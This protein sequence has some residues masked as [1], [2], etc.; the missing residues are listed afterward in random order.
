MSL[1]PS[2]KDVKR[3]LEAYAAEDKVIE[4][5]KAAAA[6]AGI[7]ALTVVPANGT[8]N[9]TADLDHARLDTV[10]RRI[11]AQTK[12]GYVLDRPLSGTVTARF[13][14][15]PL[16]PAIDVLLGVRGLHSEA[17][18]GVFV[19]RPGR[20]GA[21]SPPPAPPALAEAISTEVALDA[22]DVTTATNILN[23]LYPPSTTGGPPPAVQFGIQPNNNAVYLIGSA[24]A[25]ART[26]DILRQ[27][28]QEPSH[29]LIEAMVVEFDRDALERLGMDLANGAN[30]ELS[31]VNIDFGALLREAITFTKTAGAHNPRAFTVLIDL[32][33]ARNRARLVSRPYV[34]TLSGVPATI[35]ITNSRYVVSQGVA[36]GTTIVTAQ[37][38][39]SGVTLTIT[40]TVTAANRIRVVAS[41]TDSQ[42]IP[43]T[44][45]VAVEVDQNQASTT[46]LLDDGQSMVIGGLTLD[47]TSNA[48]SGVPFLRSIPI[49]NLLFAN[50][51]H[52]RTQQEVLIVV[53]P[54]VWTPGM[55]PPITEPDAFSIKN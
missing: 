36:A 2:D 14:N 49:I 17:Q 4:Q 40:P 44:G 38:V 8:F 15:L 54:H 45:N 37:A 52:E 46:M 12:S 1:R 13:D 9:V 5:Q 32:L 21:V 6:D 26:V 43:T 27:A 35:N 30:K 28:D 47:R 42:F 55:N 50:Q 39:P 18:A 41:V 33:Q 48:N 34:S 23:G 19:I 20:A 22:L 10:V 29:V 16:Q 7:H 11:F 31:N 24:D 53:T 51:E 3:V 25:V